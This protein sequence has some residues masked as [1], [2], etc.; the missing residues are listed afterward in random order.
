MSDTMVMG[1]R[2]RMRGLGDGAAALA[3]LARWQAAMQPGE[4]AP[5]HAM[6][7]SLKRF[8]AVNL[9]YGEEAGDRLLAEIGERI[10]KFAGDEFGDEPEG[11]WLVSR[12]R[13]GTFLLAALE[14]CSRERWQWLA[15][16]LALAIAHPIR[17][18]DGD[19]MVRLWPRMA[20]LRAVGGEEPQRMLGRLGEALE[21]GRHNPG[22]RFCWVDG[23]VSLP[24]RPAQQ[25]EADLIG[26]IERGGIEVLYQP[27]FTCAGDT[28]VGAEALARWQHPELG[29]IGA[30]ALFAIAER[31][32]HVGQL[33]R[34]IAREALAGASSWPAHLRLSLNIT[35]AD[36]ATRDFADTIAGAVLDAGFNP[37]R[38]T[39]EITEQVLVTD[40]ERS[41]VRLRQLA[42]LGIS[43]A[44]DDFG[45]GF[46]NFRYLKLLPLHT[47]KLDRSMIDGILEDPRDLAVLR[48]ILAM[49]RALDLEVVAEGIE[50]EEQ[51]DAVAREGCFAWQ[52]FLGAKPMGPEEFALLARAPSDIA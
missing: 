19:G 16:E 3:E 42:D 17:T 26:A 51:R 44:L 12:L 7:L 10:V 32:D 46:C 1:G 11:D 2:E 15:E 23:T 14:A 37:E 21:S 5:I 28:L 33:S 18:P 34:R 45:A 22:Q 41:A 9:A 29:R 35:P 24:S 52:G 39:L 31:T 30:G 20:L 8:S 47:L 25:L 40:F 49:A 43:I 36:L 38:L 13:G 6:L 4:T 48:A 50:T 27:Q